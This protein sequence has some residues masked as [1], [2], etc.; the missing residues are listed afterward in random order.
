MSFGN[1]VQEMLG[2]ARE[3]FINGDYNGAEV[4]LS[5][6]L[7]RNGRIP[8]VFQMLA[9]IYY[10]RGQFNKAIKTF[11]RALEI[12]P[13]YT[14]ASVGLSII[15]NDLGRYDEGKKV[16]V[17]AQ[18]VLDKRTKQQD[19]FVNEKLANKHEELADLYFQYQKYHDALENLDKALKLSTRK[20]EITM[21]Q[22]ECYI[23]L[24]ESDK[25]IREL[26]ALVKDY[27]HYSSARHKLGII[28]YNQNKIAEAIE[29]WEAVL[30][31]DPKNQ[32]AL[33]YIKMAKSRG[34][35]ELSL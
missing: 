23:K 18:S 5:Q 26:R 8:E 20:A 2:I 7:L 24:N 33:K 28:L 29:Q 16:F 30:V 19:P 34:L 27:P 35:R 1:D 11:K 10:D 32:D 31:K 4:I 9:T 17:E 25:A 6:V 14:D 3:K 12:D 21:R 15:L 22:A 13:S